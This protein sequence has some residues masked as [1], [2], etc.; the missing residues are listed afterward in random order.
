MRLIRTSLLLTLA[1]CRL[2]ADDP[3]LD[4]MNRIAQQQLGERE[5]AIAQI[6]TTA[7]ADRRRQLVRNKVM[8]II[9]G[10]PDYRGPLNARITVTLT[11]PD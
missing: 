11:N 5:A 7:E 10:L 1:I 4:W 6:S 3:L 9:G 2:S 8:E